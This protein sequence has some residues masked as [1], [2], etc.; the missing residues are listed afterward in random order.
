MT[1]QQG[2]DSFI[3][4]AI[5]LNPD[6]FSNHVAKLALIEVRLLSTKMILK[7]CNCPKT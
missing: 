2:A 5:Y 1:T 6:R 3:E 4:K 7:D